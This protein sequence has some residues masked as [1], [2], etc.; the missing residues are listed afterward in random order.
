MRCKYPVYRY[1]EAMVGM[2]FSITKPIKDQGNGWHGILVSY[3][4][5]IWMICGIRN[6]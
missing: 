1:L 5:G 6:R 2:A 4:L 3:I